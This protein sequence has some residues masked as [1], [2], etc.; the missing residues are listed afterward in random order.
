[1]PRRPKCLMP[2]I[3]SVFIKKPDHNQMA[4]TV[5]ISHKRVRTQAR[6]EKEMF[7][8]CLDKLD[9]LR[10]FRAVIHPRLLRELAEQS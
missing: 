2:F 4:D 9:F 3:A 7:R 6:I 1:M 10:S 8:N 5:N